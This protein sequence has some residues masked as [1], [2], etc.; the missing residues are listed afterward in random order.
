MTNQLKIQDA[1]TAALLCGLVSDTAVVLDE[2]QDGYL[3]TALNLLKREPAQNKLQTLKSI[4]GQVWKAG[5]NAYYQP[6]R[7]QLEDAESVFPA[8]DV[9]KQ[10]PIT[11]LEEL[12]EE[13]FDIQQRSPSNSSAF[14]YT[15]YHTLYAW[16]GRVAFGDSD[17]SIFDQNRLLAA[18]VKCLELSNGKPEFLLLKGALSGIQP[19]I[20]FEV[21][22]EQVG[23]A[24]KTSK[25]LRGRSYLVS[26]LCQTV[27]SWLSDELSL[28]HANIL[29][30]G[31]GHFN[32]L[33]P[34]T[35]EIKSQLATIKDR[36]NI[37]LFKE[38]GMQLSLA[39]D[40]EE[41]GEDVFT[42][43][44]KA[45][46]NISDKLDAQKQKRYLNQL[47]E[48]F[49]KKQSTGTFIRQKNGDEDK[50]ERIGRLIP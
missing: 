39:M 35:E 25:R 26:Q 31:G 17:V 8:S 7:L 43:A 38:M 6:V 12:H 41:V 22:S 11:A 44:G 48:F 20:Y 19:F 1:Y 46:K 36:L 49:E 33:L 9:Q 29:F 32:M 13:I 3:M 21:G 50:H 18:T 10:V 24:K 30:V 37:Q 2:R 15:L 28:E 42:D 14:R 5:I 27:S 4:T 45:F 23:D 40:W 47:Q 34:N 16:G